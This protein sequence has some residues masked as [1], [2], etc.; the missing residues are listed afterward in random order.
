LIV[1][2]SDNAMADLLERTLAEQ[3]VLRAKA[4]R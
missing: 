1:A 2:S 4:A 3:P